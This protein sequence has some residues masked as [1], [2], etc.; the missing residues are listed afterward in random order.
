MPISD[1]LIEKDKT[2]LYYLI[3]VTPPLRHYKDIINPKTRRI[4]IGNEKTGKVNNY[5]ISR[6]LKELQEELKIVARKTKS[7]IEYYPIKGFLD[8]IIEKTKKNFGGMRD[9]LIS[10]IKK[11]PFVEEVSAQIS[12]AYAPTSIDVYLTYCTLNRSRQTQRRPTGWAIEEYKEDEMICAKKT[13]D[14][15]NVSL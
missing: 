6:A 1:E 7:D 2:A 5:R 11:T 9:S 12:Q 15:G 8:Q 14:K 4:F 3:A 13:S 10:K